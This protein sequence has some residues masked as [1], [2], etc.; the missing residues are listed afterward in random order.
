MKFIL[1]FNL[2]K[3]LKIGINT[4]INFHII[5]LIGTATNPIIG[6]PDKGGQAR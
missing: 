5:H 4:I 6:K 1:L 2:I 3:G